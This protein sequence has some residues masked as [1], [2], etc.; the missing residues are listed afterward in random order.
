MTKNDKIKTVILV[1]KAQFK[2]S[3]YFNEDQLNEKL[4]RIKTL[5]NANQIPIG[6]KFADALEEEVI[7]KSIHGT[8]GIEGNPLTEDEV[9][10]L[11]DKTDPKELLDDAEQQIRNLQN[12]YDILK[13]YGEVGF[14]PSINGDLYGYRTILLLSI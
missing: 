8:A 11:L 14:M 9:G 2:M 5:Y 3:R 7:R 1:N 10:D 6:Q 4:L 12:A 13:E